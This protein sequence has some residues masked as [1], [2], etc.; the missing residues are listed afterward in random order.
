MLRKFSIET[1]SLFQL[2]EAPS[3][4]EGLRQLQFDNKTESVNT[5]N[6][7]HRCDSLQSSWHIFRIPPN[8]QFTHLSPHPGSTSTRRSCSPASTTSTPFGSLQYFSTPMPSSSSRFSYQCQ[9]LFYQHIFVGLNV[10]F[11]QGV[12]L[13]ALYLIRWEKRTEC[14]NSNDDCD[15]TW[16]DD[17]SGNPFIERKH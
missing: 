16:D 15:D 7:L 13:S 9:K 4:S 6:I 10:L 3:L 11:L 8:P 17:N 14:L 1:N 12:F 5:I 2:V